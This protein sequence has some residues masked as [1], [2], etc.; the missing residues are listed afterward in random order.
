MVRTL[1][2][3]CLLFIASSSSAATL[4]GIIS[5]NEQRQ[6]MLQLE[7]DGQKLY[8][9]TPYPSVKRGLELLHEG[10]YLQGDGRIEIATGRIK[11]FS[12]ESVGL[13]RI[14]GEWIADNNDIYHFKSFKNLSVKVNRGNP[15]PTTILRRRPAEQSGDVDY[16][17]AVKSENSGWP[18]IFAGPDGTGAG[19][20]E[21]LNADTL[22]I[23]IFDSQTFEFVDYILRPYSIE[24]LN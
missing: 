23:S 11:L 20:I 19:E 2:G 24:T 12:I 3:L 5:F 1:F 22:R 4:S 8:L 16:Q 13:K 18:M 17:L 21:V 10:D 14:L 9:S 6:P 7:D 15:S